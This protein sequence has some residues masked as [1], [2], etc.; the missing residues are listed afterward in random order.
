MK[1]SSRLL[2]VLCLATRSEKRKAFTLIE[3][4]VVIA[5]IAL[6]AAILFPVFARAR[7]NARKSSCANNLKQIGLAMIQYAQDYD[8]ILPPG[9][10]LVPTA[11]AWDHFIEPYAMNAGTKLYG[12]G[13]AAYLVCPS[14]GVTRSTAGRAKRSYAIPMSAFATADYAWL[15]EPTTNFTPGRSLAEFPATSKTLMVVEYQGT[16]AMIGTN[17]GYRVGSG[18]GQVGGAAGPAHLEGWNYCFV[19]GHVKWYK[20]EQTVATPGVAYSTSYVNANGFNCYG[21]MTRSCGMWTLDPND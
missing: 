14:D 13:Q 18:S 7:E 2:P 20:P 12:T 19:D 6:L 3:L 5:I 11:Y 10:N 1:V 21:N 16:D 4:L 17:G 8:E 15:A 9:R